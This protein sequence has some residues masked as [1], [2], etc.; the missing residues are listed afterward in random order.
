M[1]ASTT[2][3]LVVTD[4]VK[5]VPAGEGKKYQEMKGQLKTHPK[6][7]LKSRDPW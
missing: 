1:P 6:D 4:K 3:D 5:E 7:K 2:V